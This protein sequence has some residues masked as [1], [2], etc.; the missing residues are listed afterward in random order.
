MSV[1]D[2]ASQTPHRRPSGDSPAH[3]R[4][5]LGCWQGDN[6]SQRAG[7]PT[8]TM[9]VASVLAHTQ[10]THF[11]YDGS[12]RAGF[13]SGQWQPACWLTHFNYRVLQKKTAIKSGMKRFLESP[14]CPQLNVADWSP[15]MYRPEWL[16]FLKAADTEP[17]PTTLKLGYQGLRR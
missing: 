9:M 15:D 16:F 1:C 8:S 12:Q 4:E 13:P 3:R 2:A 10:F 5:H 7:L 6:G 11:N 14:V 17:D